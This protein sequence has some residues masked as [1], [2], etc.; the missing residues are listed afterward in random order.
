M[1]DKELKEE[2]VLDAIFNPIL[3]SDIL[4][5]KP[6]QEEDTNGTLEETEELVKAKELELSGVKAAENGD[7][8]AA[9]KYFDQAIETC[10]QGASGYNNRAQLLRLIC[11]QLSFIFFPANLRQE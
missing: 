4:A 2:E 5:A 7:F 9:L 11:E 1:A 6:E 10:P 3:S 8:D